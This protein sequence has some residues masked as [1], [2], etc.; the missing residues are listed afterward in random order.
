VQTAR[1]LKI[2]VD[3]IGPNPHNPRR[4]FD[5]EPMAILRESVR[6]PGILVP[7][8]L[9]EAPKDQAPAG[10]QYILLD[11]ERRW[12]CAQELKIPTIPAIVVERPTETQNILTM[13]HI[14]YVREGWQRMPTAL[15]LK[16][17]IDD[18]KETN[19]RKLSELTKLSVAQVR[20]CKILLSYPKRFQNMM[21]APPT[22]RMKADFFIELDRIRR[23]ALEDRI[24]PWIEHGDSETI[25]ILLS[26]SDDHPRLVFL[27]LKKPIK[28]RNEFTLLTACRCCPINLG[29]LEH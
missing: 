2:Q 9:Y 4:L 28:F 17:L 15:K 22:E 14:H 10:P 27:A 16:V 8:T 5:E 11:G 7:V 13:F 1:V 3:Q 12:R 25:S 18:L 19:K 21:L 20:R 24:E 23:P 6:K 26:H 29:L